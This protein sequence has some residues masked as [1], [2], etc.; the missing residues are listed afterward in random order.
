[1][2]RGSLFRSDRDLILQA[3]SAVSRRVI[4]PGAS[5]IVR[6]GAG[7]TW[8]VYRQKTTTADTFAD[9]EVCIDPIT[10]DPPAREIRGA[11]SRGVTR[12]G[13]TPCPDHGAGAGAASP[14]PRAP[15]PS[16]GGGAVGVAVAAGGRA[17]A[18][19]SPV[20]APRNDTIRRTCSSVSSRPSW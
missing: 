17:S 2:Q 20:S 9:R 11:P 4:S 6:D 13:P 10:I 19:R 12:P 1:M 15:E 5:S 14:S 7:R 3:C 8:M 16:G 18:G